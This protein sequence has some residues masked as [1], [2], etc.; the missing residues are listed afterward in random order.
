[1]VGH[2]AGRDRTPRGAAARRQ[3]RDRTQRQRRD[4]SGC[5]ITG[6]Y[7]HR[8][9]QVVRASRSRRLVSRRDDGNLGE[10]QA[11][12]VDANRGAAD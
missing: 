5:W 11:E 12:A 1:M 8:L 2:G 6:E 10:S 7:P 3:A 9:P 4:R